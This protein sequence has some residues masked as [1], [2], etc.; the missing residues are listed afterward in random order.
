MKKKVL[1]VV[2]LIVAV[3]TM[4]LLGQHSMGVRIGGVTQS[5][6]V[7]VLKMGNIQVL[8]GVDYYGASISNTYSYEY[9]EIYYGERY[10]E[11]DEFEIEGKL[12]L[13]IPRI[14]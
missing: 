1:L 7:G 13:L 6:Y 3:T 5:F 9:E 4:P 14:G 12:S 11:N 8:G 10:T 2:I